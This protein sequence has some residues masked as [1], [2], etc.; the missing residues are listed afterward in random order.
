MIWENARFF[1]CME[2]NSISLYSAVIS[3]LYIVYTALGVG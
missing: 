1:N 3:M 2:W